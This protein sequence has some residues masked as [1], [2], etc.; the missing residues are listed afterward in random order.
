MNHRSR[1][2]PTMLAVVAALLAL[3]L[4]ACGASSSSDDASTKAEDPETT[5]TGAEADESAD[6]PA[7]GDDPIADDASGDDYYDLVL[8][9]EFCQSIP[10]DYYLEA[11]G[12][13]ITDASS[14]G[15][16]G[17]NGDI[18]YSSTMCA[19]VLDDGTD[20]SAEILTDENEELSG[21]ELFAALAGFS[22]AGDPAELPHEA[23]DGLG[24]DAVFLADDFRNKLLVSHMDEVWL[25]SATDDDF[26]TL[27]RGTIVKIAHATFAEPD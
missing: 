20:I 8:D 12:G 5:T 10:E 14:G 22:E 19:F 23:V 27:D 11:T 16:F 1:Q 4:A 25:F 9:D 15:G 3:L 21:P 13:M 17:L 26:E 2:R 6:N 7:D 24:E 18:E